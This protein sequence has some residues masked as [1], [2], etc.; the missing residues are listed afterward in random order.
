MLRV[1]SFSATAPNAE[2]TSVDARAISEVIF[3]G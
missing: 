3:D 1:L 2:G